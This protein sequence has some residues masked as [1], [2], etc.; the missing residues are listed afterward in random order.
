MEEWKGG[1]TLGGLHKH[2]KY[3]FNVESALSSLQLFLSHSPFLLLSLFIEEHSN[4]EIF[5]T[6]LEES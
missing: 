5:L 2:R 4:V 6:I 3:R 1:W